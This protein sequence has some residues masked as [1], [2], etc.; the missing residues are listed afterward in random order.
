ME[1]YLRNIAYIGDKIDNAD[2]VYNASELILVF[3][4]LAL[5]GKLSKKQYKLSSYLHSQ[6]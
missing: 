5:F 1:I 4:Y 2:I 3:D 6:A